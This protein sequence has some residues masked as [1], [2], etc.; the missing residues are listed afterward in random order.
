M[1]KQNRLI[2]NA[3]KKKEAIQNS[4]SNNNSNNN[5]S[6]MNNDKNE[7]SF[8]GENVNCSDSEK[9]IT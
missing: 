9:Q 5:N 7:A 2:R 6:K 1:K 4:S 8:Y 3:K